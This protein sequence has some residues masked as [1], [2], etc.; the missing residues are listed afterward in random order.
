V[1]DPEGKSMKEPQAGQVMP[2]IAVPSV[3][4][5]REFYVERLGFGHMMGVLGSD[6]KL[7]F[8]TVIRDGGKIMFTRSSAPHTGAPAV[9]LYFRVE[10]VDDF[11][12]R[13][14]GAGVE[15][16]QPENMWWGDRVF[17]AIDL[18]GYRLWFYQTVAEPLPPAG[19]KIV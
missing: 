12:H 19:S 5:A 17:I 8:C 15:V 6:G 10:D 1:N 13:L 4:E 14:A 18:N 3:D 11:H 9:E 16:T 7:D 2:M